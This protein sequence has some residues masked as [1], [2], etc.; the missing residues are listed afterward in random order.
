MSEISFFLLKLNIVRD[1]TGRGIERA[2]AE[3]LAAQPV[4]LDEL[5][6]RAWVMRTWLT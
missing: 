6:D 1:R 2:T 3:T 4:V 5:R